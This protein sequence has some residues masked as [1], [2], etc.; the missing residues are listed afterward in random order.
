MAEGYLSKTYSTRSNVNP[1]DFESFHLGI[2]IAEL[3]RS[4]PCS[5]L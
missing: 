3:S 1:Y 5:V 2:E 4:L